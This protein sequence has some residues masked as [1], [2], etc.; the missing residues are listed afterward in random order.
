MFQTKVV[1]KITIHFAFNNFIEN[2][3]FFE[4]M[5]KNI[6][7]PD[8]TQMT[9]YGAFALRVGYLRLHTHTHTHTHTHKHA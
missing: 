9:T 3:D 1:E 5:W 2:H 6:V 4:K 7:E 8:K